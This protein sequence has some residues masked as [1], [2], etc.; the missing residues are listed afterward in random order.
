MLVG[1]AQVTD[2]LK[3]VDSGLAQLYGGIGQLPAQ[4]QPIHDGIQS[5]LQGIGTISTPGI[6]LFGVNAVQVGLADATAPGGAVDLL[7]GGVDQV[8][9]GLAAAAAGL[10]DPTTPG[11]TARYG[12]AQVKL[13]MDAGL[14][15]GGSNR[16]VDRRCRHGGDHVRLLR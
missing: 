1:L 2:G 10:G 14:V 12:V 16:P 15:P 8:N 4:A 13:G 6:L 11:L 5:M 3:K 7:K 9:A